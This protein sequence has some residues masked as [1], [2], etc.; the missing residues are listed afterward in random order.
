MRVS[1]IK[2]MIII[3]VGWLTLFSSSAQ[4]ESCRTLTVQSALKIPDM[5][6]PRDSPNG[7]QIGAVVATGVISSFSCTQISLT[8][9]KSFGGK[10][11][12]SLVSVISGRGVYALGNS[13]VGYT[14]MATDYDFCKKSIY[15]M[16]DDRNAIACSGAD[17]EQ[18]I[19]GLTF[20]FYKIGPIKPG[21]VPIQRLG[22]MILKVG[23]GWHSPE[24]TVNSSE[25]ILTS[26]SCTVT[27][28][29]ITVPM[30]TVMAS[31]FTQVGG[32]TRE[33][34]FSIP[35]NCDEGVKVGI[36]VSA[37]DAGS[38]DAANGLINLGKLSSAEMAKGVKLQILS[39]GKPIALDTVI[40]VRGSSN[41]GMLSIPL[42][43]RYYQ[44]SS[45]ITA[46]QAGAA[47]N[48]VMTYE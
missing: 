12:G 11:Y 17:F 35:L 37:S 5:V 43:A 41:K 45:P 44:S 31:D 32:T 6:V 26:Q 8:N 21:K 23:N 4:A 48:F 22:A 10:A 36:T 24:A 38:W 30:G 29:N 40:G 27:N 33:V 15:V 19:G 47:A 39:E 7:T 25:F 3:F 13:G 1:S 14:I 9:I 16:A 20:T 42:A 28:T 34:D 18:M 46:G 2:Y